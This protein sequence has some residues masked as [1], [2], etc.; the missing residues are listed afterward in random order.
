MFCLSPTSL[1]QKAKQQLLETI[2]GVNVVEFK[3]QCAGKEEIHDDRLKII[4][5]LENYL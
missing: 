2:H 4:D 5:N 3:I 1:K